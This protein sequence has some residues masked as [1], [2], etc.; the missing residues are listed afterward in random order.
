MPVKN[1]LA[2]FYKKLLGFVCPREY[3]LNPWSGLFLGY[4]DCRKFQILPFKSKVRGCGA[5]AS[6][7]NKLNPVVVI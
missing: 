3:L 2:K 4:K 5:K 7:K 6:S 1:W